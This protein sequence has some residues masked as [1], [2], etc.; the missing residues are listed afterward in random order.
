MNSTPQILDPPAPPQQSVQSPA[1]PPSPSSDG[2]E[3]RGEEA[4]SLVP[5]GSTN[6]APQPT[7]PPPHPAF[8]TGNRGNGKIAR[9]PKTVR[10]QINNWLMDGL[11]YPDI[12]D[13][14]GEHGKELKPN[15]LY[16]WKKRGYHDWLIERDW[17]ERLSSKA[18][19]SSD[20]LAAPDSSNL[21]EAGLRIA[22]SQMFDQLMRFTAA[23]PES[24][25]SAGHPEVFARLVNALSRLTREALHFQK[26]R[27]AIAKAAI[28]LKKLD[29]DRDLSE[30]EF[31]LLVN[32]MDKVFKVARP[33][34]TGSP[35]I[36][37]TH[38]TKPMAPL[39]AASLASCENSSL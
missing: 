23:S 27:D 2:G 20:I 8:G 10:D 13:R 12:I 25:E 36:P 3:G 4:R 15:H 9:L 6:H 18:E 16:E 32:Q 5:N 14:L 35:I 30:N 17:L 1:S 37:A 11:S 26:Y 29:P 19:F 24:P 7:D 21:H 33:R 34:K 39:A 22:A 31:D 38:E 28:E